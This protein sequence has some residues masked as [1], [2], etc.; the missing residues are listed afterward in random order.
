MKSK[1]LRRWI[2]IHKW[3]SLSC[4]IFLLILCLVGLPL[5]FGDEIEDLISDELPLADVPIKTPNA[6]YDA[7]ARVARALHPYEVTVWMGHD[8]V[9]PR[10]TVVMAPSG[11][12][13]D[14]TSLRQSSPRNG[15]I[16]EYGR[17]L[18]AI[19]AP[20]SGSREPGD[21]LE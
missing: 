11:G 1:N 12:S 8:A 5:V 2:W 21:Q 17:R 13:R 7:F 9:Q 20:I 14:R 16:S 3:S 10:I 18:S 6:S 4:T 19:V 15:N